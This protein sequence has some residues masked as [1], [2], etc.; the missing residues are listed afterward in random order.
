[1]SA[2]TPGVEA[3]ARLFDAM[4]PTYDDLEPWYE[5]LYSRLHALLDEVLRPAPG[6]PPGRAL[7]AGCGTGLQA[8]RLQALGYRTHG[9]DLS[10]ALLVVARQRSADLQ[11]VRGRLEALPYATA[12]FDVV[13]CCG[14]TLSFVADPV[15][16]LG[17]LGRV[18]RPGGRL[19]V[20]CEHAWNLD[21]VWALADAV[22]GGRLG[23]GLTLGQLWRALR[24]H[25]GRWLP[26]PG[27]GPLRLFTTAELRGLLAAA[28]LTLRRRWGIHALTNLRPSTVLHRPRLGPVTGLLFR[29]LAAADDA[30]RPWPALAVLANSLVVLADRS[31]GDAA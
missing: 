16:A 12:T 13:A 5:H 14:S 17:E 30:L 19:L 27:Y 15:R 20:E 21:L 26:Y 1:M 4:A 18:L 25:G 31:E 7:D 22:S 29:A 28:G 2:P 8:R 9:L 23:Y 6:T 10:H 11:L 24:C 3:V